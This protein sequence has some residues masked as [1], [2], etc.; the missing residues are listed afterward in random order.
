[1]AKIGDTVR[2][3]SATG[4]G[5][6]RKI[7][8]NVAYVEDSDG[9]ETPSLLKDLVVVMPAGHTGPDVKGANLMFDQKAFDEG[10]S[11]RKEPQP[12]PVPA[13][14][15]PAPAP[16]TA[17]G[18]KLSITLAFEPDDYKNI[19]ATKFSAVLVNDSNYT[20]YVVFLRK[21]DDS[22]M[23]EIIYRGEAAPNELLDLA[24][25]SHEDLPGMQRVAL[26]YVAFRPGREA[27]L[28]APGTA[29]IRLDLT[30]FHKAHCF[31]PGRY[32][33]NPVMEIA[34]VADDSPV[35]A[36]EIDPLAIKSSML[37]DKKA[38]R[39]LK[40]KYSPAKKDKKR[41]RI[42]S[43]TALLPLIETDLHIDALT[44]TTAGMNNADM[45]TLQLDTVRRIMKENSRRIGQKIV[46]IHGKGEGVLRKEMLK[47]LSRE[48]PKATV[49]DASFRE[50]GFGASLV[51]IH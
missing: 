18:D 31:R 32:F 41:E 2:Y 10:R 36:P 26:Q 47:V 28:K 17:Y 13:H 15:A 33:E 39:E 42:P 9:F 24:R 14:E 27:L 1:M 38:L 22:G 19:S 12:E 23:W 34:L 43:P 37:S 35:R 29:E 5:V 46:F 25:F 4:G 30:K 48:F 21:G 44:D 40:E 3:L 8:G 50:Y 20:L 45:L 16:D 7:E 51:T 6:I 49:Q 11:S